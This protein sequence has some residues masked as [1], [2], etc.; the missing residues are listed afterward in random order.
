MGYHDVN[1]LLELVRLS[2]KLS[3]L[4]LGVRA[5]LVALWKM[6]RERALRATE[7]VSIYTV[8]SVCLHSA[9][10]LHA[11]STSSGYQRIDS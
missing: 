10:S 7:S 1:V 5:Q 3:G 8:L 4:H 6:P 9:Q 11:T 2:E